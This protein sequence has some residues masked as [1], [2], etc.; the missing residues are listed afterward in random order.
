MAVT[1]IIVAVT[2]N[3]MIKRE[4]DFCR[5]KAIRFAIKFATFRICFLSFQ[6]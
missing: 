1:L 5:L 4:N 6:K 3:R 2:D